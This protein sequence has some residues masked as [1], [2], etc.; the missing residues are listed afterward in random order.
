MVLIDQNS[1][2]IQSVTD[3]YIYSHLEYPTGSQQL[4]DEVHLFYH[5]YKQWQ[6]R[7][8]EKLLIHIQYSASKCISMGITY[9]NRYMEKYSKTP[10]GYFSN[11]V[12]RCIHER[13]QSFL[14]EANNHELRYET[15][16]RPF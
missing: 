10:E 1:K 4:S 11:S 9:Y 13:I 3:G 16:W 14:E 7:K 5:G 2:Y 6:Q 15:L 12:Y 8:Y